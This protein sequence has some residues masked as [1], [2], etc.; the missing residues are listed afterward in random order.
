MT[1]FAMAPA[2][3]DQPTAEH[4]MQMKFDAH[5]HGPGGGGGTVCPPAGTTN[6]YD[7]G[8]KILPTAHLYAIW[9]GAD[10]AWPSDTPGALSSFFSGM[11]GSAY[12]KTADQY[13]RG[14][15]AQTLFAGSFSDTTTS[16]PHKTMTAA[17]LGTEVQHVLSVNNNRAVDP[18]AIYFVFTANAPNG[19]GFCAWHDSTSVNGQRVAVAYMPNMGGVAGCDPG[20]QYDTTGY[21][22]TARELANVTAHEMM[23]AITDA[24]PSVATAWIDGSGSEIGDKCAW[25]FASGLTLGSSLQ[26]QL[27]EEWSNGTSGCVQTS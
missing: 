21:S 15:T 20:N 12:L 4:M 23:E 9:W 6:L 18:N 26:W 25:Q 7:C 24:Q 5:G 17:M 22:E 13:M 2:H 8:G 3:A 27:Q 16:L 10:S 14:G 1:T 19:G 11:N